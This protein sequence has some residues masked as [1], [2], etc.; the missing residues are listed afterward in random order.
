MPFYC[1]VTVSVD[2]G[3]ATEIIYLDY[4]K[5]FGM[6]SHN[7]LSTKLERYVFGGWTVRRLRNLLEVCILI[8]TVNGSIPKW[9]PVR[10]GAP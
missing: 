3:R 9:I 6:V 5:A 4:C 8:V 7:I 2:K 1:V 10:S